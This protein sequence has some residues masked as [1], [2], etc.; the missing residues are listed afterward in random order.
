[1]WI[2]QVALRRPYTFVVMAIAIVLFGALSAVTTPVDI[3]PDIGI[4]VISVVWS[5]ADMEPDDISGRLVYFFERL[6]STQVSD[7][8]HIESQSLINYGVVK[9]FFQPSV[10]VN[11]ALAST[12][13]AAETVLKF[14][15]QGTVPPYVLK[16]SASSVPVIG[17]ALS[18]TSI[19]EQQLWNLGMNFIRPQLASVPGIMTTT[20]YGGKILQV[21]ADLNLQA[22]QQFGVSPQDVADGIN[23]QNLIIP[24]GDQKVG[25]FD[26]NVQTNASPVDVTHTNTFP[27][28][29]A[30]G[31][32]VY[33]PDVAY[34]HFGFPPQTNVVRLNGVRAA[35]LQIEKSGSTST[36]TII[37][38]VKNLLPLVK[39]SMPSALKITAVGDQS[40][41]VKGAIDGVIREGLIAAVL[42]GIMILLFLGNWRATVIIS[43]SIPLAVLSSIIALS[44]LGETLNQM[45][46]GGLALAVGM[47]VDE[48]TVTIE[49][50]EYHRE[51][52][53]DIETA[54]LDGAQQ[55]VLPALLSLLAICIV[56]A[57]MF[58]LG[59]VAHFLFVPFAESVVFAMIASWVLSRTLVPT[60]AAYMMRDDSHHHA[61]DE[62][63][64]DGKAGEDAKQTHGGHRDKPPSRNPLV[65]LQ[66]G[67]DRGFE[68]LRHGYHGLLDL[69]LANRVKF[70]I[71]FMIVVVL[72]YGLAPFLGEDFFPRVDGGAIALHVRAQTGTRIEM[73]TRLVAQVDDYIR[74]VIPPRQIANILDNID[75]P[76]S[77]VNLAY[78]NTGSIGPQDADIVVTL[79]EDHR[80]SDYYIAILRKQLPRRFPG[81]T[82]AFL[83]ADI[84]SKILNFGLPSPIDIM[85]SGPHQKENYAYMRKLF[86][87]VRKIPG[88]VDV[89]IQQEFNYP[90]LNIHIDRS[91]AKLVGINTR[92]LMQ[93]V[94]TLLAGDYQTSPNFWLNYET[95]VSYPIVAQ[96]PQYRMDTIND[97]VNVPITTDARKT[98]SRTTLLGNIAQITLS[99]SDAV[100][101]HYNVQ[102]AV[103]I[104]GT[105]EG[106]DLGAIGSDIHSAIDSLKDDRPPGGVVFLRGQAQTMLDAYRQLF[107]G[108]FA[109][110]VLIYLMLVVNFQSWL[111]PFIIITALP[112][113]LSGIVWMLFTTHTPLS[114]PALTGA[115]MTMGVATANSILV[116]SFCRDQLAEGKDSNA[117][118]LEAGF[119]RIRPVMMTAL[120]MIIG[121]I[122]M[123]LGLGDGGAQNAPLGRAVIGGLMFATVSTLFLVPVV[124][125]IMHR[126]DNTSRE[127]RS[128]AH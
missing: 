70:M 41:F 53:K 73:T 97:L 116:V 107:F 95:G 67:F 36:L 78:Q 112:A 75:M 58:L 43:T 28:K 111:D 22:M 10:N 29:S 6:L 76:I 39:E 8:E 85:V 101:S 62:K 14:L 117:A 125:S 66:R 88:F 47:L 12:A 79:S 40:I 63:P 7:I 33:L 19:S 27:V 121:M 102:P 84:T 2:V 26:W 123:S 34:S 38:G 61:P 92:D 89:R 1:M 59:G 18:S 4:P 32:L 24:G 74:T 5:Y 90:Q 20:P 51:M 103:D 127:R 119:V 48:A 49:S 21:Q 108:L 54:I 115:I 110:I 124:F 83:P 96:S 15:P 87:K 105:T 55:I 64:E 31:T 104:Y 69:A 93:S 16:F 56:F 94:Y 23:A 17:I 80:P 120:A 109:S 25:K 106:R 68:N 50:I 122:P 128:A 13:A 35:L 98:G 11:S 57:P 82:F 86:K 126:K 81:A 114:V 3:F 52:G 42:T 44:A 99:P 77:G 60:M 37:D 118:A 30:N 72:S 45:T 71:G 46:L 100:V 65:N 91:L 113:A 9:I